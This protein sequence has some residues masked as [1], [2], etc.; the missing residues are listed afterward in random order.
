LDMDGDLDVVLNNLEDQASIYENLSERSTHFLQIELQ[1]TEDNFNGVGALVEIRTDRL[2]QVQSVQTSRGFQS[3]VEPVL[4]FGLGTY[5]FVD[6]LTVRWP[7]GS[8]NSMKNVQADERIVIS[9]ELAQPATQTQTETKV[10]VTEITADTDM[11]HQHTEHSFNDYEKEVLLP[12]KY[13]QLGPGIAVGDVNGDG[14]EDFYIG[15]ARDFAGGLYVQT[16]SGR[17]KSTSQP[18]WNRDKQ[19]E[20]IDAAFYDAY[21]FLVFEGALYQCPDFLL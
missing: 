10:L 12:H 1:G 6:E 21:L 14:I 3:S 15:G 18:T 9:Q 5:D 13:S 7:N 16:P 2:V 19:Y 11:D 4:H 17:F 20:D 8:I